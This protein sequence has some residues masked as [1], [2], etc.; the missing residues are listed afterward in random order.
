LKTTGEVNAIQI[1]RTNF[2]PQKS[3]LEF[4]FEVV[5]AEDERSATLRAAATGISF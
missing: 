1:L 5:P 3:E 2:R 4:A